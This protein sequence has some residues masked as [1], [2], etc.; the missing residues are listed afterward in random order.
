TVIA[1]GE[2]GASGRQRVRRGRQHG[3]EQEDRGEDG[4]ACWLAHVNAPASLTL[5]LGDQLCPG[6]AASGSWMTGIRSRGRISQ[7][8]FVTAV[9]DSNYVA[10]RIV[11]GRRRA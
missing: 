6:S 5:F 7:P 4:E 8:A 1:A 10:R 11:C 2:S 3:G 9:C